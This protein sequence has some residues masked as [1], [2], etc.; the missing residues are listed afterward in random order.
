MILR[1]H[2][3]AVFQKQLKHL[4]QAGGLAALAA[5][6]AESIVQGIA[7][8]GIRRTGEA[9]RLTRHG[10]ARLKNCIKYDLVGA[11][12]LLAFKEGDDLVFSFVGTH[13]E[14]TRWIKNNAN[15]SGIRPLVEKRRNETCPVFPAKNAAGQDTT[16]P[17]VDDLADD[18][19]ERLL[20]DLDEKDLRKLFC[21]LCKT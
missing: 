5:D 17:E 1:V 6:H 19:I 13:D 7:N 9:G 12:R 15:N 20:A 8:Q 3:D 11:Y 4:R 10:E 16:S 2:R 21:G 14:C 18:Y